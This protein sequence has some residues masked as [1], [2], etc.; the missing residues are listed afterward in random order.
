MKSVSPVLAFVALLAFATLTNAQEK[1]AEQAVR[2]VVADFAEAINRGDTKSFAALFTEDADF[3]VI[4]G[5]S[6]KGR[7]EI[8][9]YHAGLFTGD[10]QDSHLGVTSVSVRFLRPDVAVARAATRR[11]ENGG[12]AMRTSFPM[13][14][15]TKQG[16]PW[17]IA[18]VQNTLTSGPPVPPVGARKLPQIGQ[19][20]GPS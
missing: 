18:A 11:T 13:F 1:S 14:V 15:L 10:F 3:V 2:R 20:T 5:K 19:W 9:T 17:L 16:E 12:K 8:A 4:A 6:L 7:N